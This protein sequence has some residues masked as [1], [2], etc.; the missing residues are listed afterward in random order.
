MSTQAFKLLVV[1]DDEFNRDLLHELLTS[2]GYEVTLAED[3]EAAW[4]MLA[5]NENKFAAIL[6]DRM[7]PRLD[8]MGLL[9]RLKADARFKDV[10]VIFQTAIDHPAEIAEGIKAGA[11]YYL[12][13]PINA[14]VLFAIVQ[15][16]VSTF[17]LTSS[18]RQNANIEQAILAHMLVRGEYQLR[19]LPEV[20][21]LASSLAGFYPHPQ[22]V[23]LGIS[24]LLINAVEHGNLSISYAEK[25]RLLQEGKWEGEIERRLAMPEYENKMV[26]VTLEHKLHEISLTIRDDGPG[27]DSK[28]YMELSP[29]RAFDPNGR[30][31]LMSKMTSFD[32]LEYLGKGNHVVALV[33]I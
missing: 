20:R 6:L 10:P 3:G 16:A 30:G 27:F 29:D 23:F 25:S 11:F 26:A 18:L 2:A 13:K 7:M 9:L 4:E 32:S 1:E 19:T 8:G 14:G 15:S 28:K 24:E 22:R 5:R 12:V 33:K 31:I 21:T 17:D